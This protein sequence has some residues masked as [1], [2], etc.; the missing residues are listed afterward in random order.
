LTN[1]SVKPKNILTNLKKKRKESMTNIKQ[2]YNE[3]HKFKKAKRGDLTEM[4]YL[5]SKL[6]ENGYVYYIREKCESKTVQDIFWTHPTS[7]KL[8]NNF[9][10]VL[11]MDFT[12]KTNL[13]RMPLFEIVGVTSTYLT[14]SVGFAFMTSEKEDN[15][16]WALQMLLKL[17]EPNSHMPKVVVTDRDT[18]MMNAVENVFPDSSAILCYFH[19]GKNVR[20]RII[21]D[22]KVKQNVVVVDGQ[23]KIVDDAK[24]SKLVDTIF[25]A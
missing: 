22:C 15:F 10:T 23:K 4:Q 2:V 7:V 13:Y 9:P 18:S 1:S 11:V 12:Y 6:E 5:I 25:D 24:H 16:T 20:A 3:R 8:F 17:L 21:T 14:Y 19:A